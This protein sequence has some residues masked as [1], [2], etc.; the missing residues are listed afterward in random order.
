M[1]G[2]MTTN[3]EIRYMFSSQ[4]GFK[5]QLVQIYR[6]FEEE[7]IVT[8]KLYKLRQTASAMVYITKFQALLV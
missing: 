6:D 8:R 7:E 5:A 1:N 4:E 3:K 2:I